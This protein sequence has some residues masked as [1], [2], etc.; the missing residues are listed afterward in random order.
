MWEEEKR[1]R[2][3]RRKKR[4]RKRRWRGAIQARK[5][6]P[7]PSKDS[8]PPPSTSSFEVHQAS[9]FNLKYLRHQASKFKF[10]HQLEVF[11]SIKPSSSNSNF[12]LLSR[13]IKLSR[14]SLPSF[15]P[16]SFLQAQ[17]NSFT[18][19]KSSKLFIH[20]VEVRPVYKDPPSVKSKIW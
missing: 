3:R 1:R 19:I 18:A 4:R 11:K 9:N 13:S 12:N 14:S 2:R 8:S 5:S 6:L 7:R 15:K 20:D 10:K 17:P 16:G